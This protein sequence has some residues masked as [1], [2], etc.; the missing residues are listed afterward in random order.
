MVS[1][2][3]YRMEV[4]WYSLPT[5]PFDRINHICHPACVAGGAGPGI[6]EAVGLLGFGAETS[7]ACCESGLVTPATSSSQY[8]R[9]KKPTLSSPLTTSSTLS[10]S[11]RRTVA[12]A[13]GEKLAL[14]TLDLSPEVT[15]SLILLKKASAKSRQMRGFQ[16]PG[17]P[18]TWRGISIV[19]RDCMVVTI[20]A[21]VRKPTTIS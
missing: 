2:F 4:N 5:R 7:L 20:P 8:Q 6:R 12:P 10:C 9:G 15:V 11:R 19:F 17:L 16:A 1:R 14:H 18:R 21:G 3:Q 13:P